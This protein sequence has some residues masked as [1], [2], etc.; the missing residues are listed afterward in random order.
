VECRESLG[1]KESFNGGRESGLDSL[2]LCEPRG[3]TVI[4][5][6]GAAYSKNKSR[7]TS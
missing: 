5:V 6:N 3:G 2:S 7:S 4:R 1:F